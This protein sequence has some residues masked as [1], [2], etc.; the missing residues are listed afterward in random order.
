MYIWVR[1]YPLE[2]TQAC[3]SCVGIEERRFIDV[4]WSSS[5]PSPIDRSNVQ[6]ICGHVKARHFA[7]SDIPGGIRKT[8]CTYMHTMGTDDCQRHISFNT[9]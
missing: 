7:V 3:Q 4:R 5:R 6:S 1:T 8:P 2:G 9:L